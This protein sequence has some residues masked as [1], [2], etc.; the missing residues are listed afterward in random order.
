MSNKKSNILHPFFCLV[1]PIRNTHFLVFLLLFYFS[2]TLFGQEQL[3]TEKDSITFLHRTGGKLDSVDI[4]YASTL[5][6]FPGGGLNFQ[7]NTL[8]PQFLKEHSG[9][10]NF[11]FL[12]DLK[13]MKFS[14]LPHIGFSY[15]F[16]SRGTQFLH[17]DY[18][19]AF[20]RKTLINVDGQRISSAGFL[21]NSKFNDNA[22]NLQLRHYDKFYSFVL[23]GSYLTKK[24]SLSDGITDDT[25]LDIQGLNFL[26]VS[27]NDA[28]D[29]IKLANAKI[30]N[31]FNFLVDSAHAIGLVTKHQYQM[32]GR[33]YRENEYIPPVTW[34]I[35]SMET[36]DQYRLAGI[37]NS[38][39]FYT[40]T[41]R[42]YFD[43]LVQ[44]R[45]WDFQNLAI[46][47]DTNELNFTS[48][49]RFNHKYFFL[50]N[51]LNFNSIGAGGEWLNKSSVSTSIGKIQL[52]GSLQIEQKLPEPI[53]RFYFSNYYNYSLAEYKLQS[54]VFTNI[55]VYYTVSSKSFIQVN[56]MNSILHNNYFFIDSLWRNDT[57]NTISINSLS[58]SGS[59]NYKIVYLIPKVTFNIPTSNFSYLPN[60]SIN[61]RVFVKK[62][63]FKAKKME[64]ITGLDISWISSYNLLDYNTPMDV[65]IFNSTTQK[66]HSMMNLSAFL[67]FTIDDFRFYA[68]MEN[69]GYFWNDKHN[70]VLIGYPIQ[71]NFLRLGITWDFFN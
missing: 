21:R 26:P 47:H 14:A 39:G 43:V 52:N 16:G 28:L 9:L 42:M 27:K 5:S 33:V 1:L 40:K 6:T 36:R 22:L 41:K 10:K 7:N 66:F 44:H 54:R 29:S 62:K 15:S 67:G 56:Y 13:P 12:S 59:M 61:A 2:E 24:I 48:S 46:H 68:R 18:Q 32:E 37:Y 4:A 8:S 69:I 57:L 50:T 71:K 60:T 58:V 38:F 64:G 34:Y 51:E 17:Y 25:Y 35:D 53:Q 23:E 49:L 30:S 65:F 11:R 63:M 20:S 55:S 3:F 31:Y 45:Y 70:Q 19:Q